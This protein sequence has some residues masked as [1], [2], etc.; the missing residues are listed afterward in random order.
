MTP[1][2]EMMIS[3][4]KMIRE[5]S[6]AKN[7][8][9][10]YSHSRLDLIKMFHS[11]FENKSNLSQ[12]LDLLL[13]NKLM[14]AESKINHMFEGYYVTELGIDLL[15]RPENFSFDNNKLERKVDTTNK[16]TGWT[17]KKL[18]L[19]DESIIVKIR[20]LATELHDRIENAHFY[21]NSDSKD[22]NS[23]ADALVNVCAMAEPD[24]SII[25]KILAHPKFKTYSIFF[26]LIATIRGALGI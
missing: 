6:F 14:D 25:E 18:I 21:S 23:L 17:G 7:P 8:N 26:G 24:I 9:G 1:L 22:L 2:D 20:Q 13:Y 11:N 16:A 12:V 19:T 4:L 3:F 5:E 15:Q 10:I